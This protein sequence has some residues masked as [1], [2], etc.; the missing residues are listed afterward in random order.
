MYKNKLVPD[1]EG[2]FEID[3][4]YTKLDVPFVYNFDINQTNEAAKQ[5]ADFEF[6]GYQ[7]LEEASGFEFDAEWLSPK[8]GGWFIYINSDTLG[9]DLYRNISLDDMDENFKHYKAFLKNQLA[10]FFREK[11]KEF[12]NFLR[13]L[14]VKAIA[15]FIKYQHSRILNNTD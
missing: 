13:Q 11:N 8:I 7:M 1:S 9:T 10:H 5:L 15:K 3:L 4:D 14:I 6:F 2:Y 12:D